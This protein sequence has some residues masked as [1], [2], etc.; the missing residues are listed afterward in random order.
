M[1]LIHE[2]LVAKYDRT[3]PPYTR[4]DYDKIWGSYDVSSI[5]T[6]IPHTAMFVPL[7]SWNDEKALTDL[8]AFAFVPELLS[9]YSSAK[10]ILTTRSVNSWHRSMQATVFAHMTSWPLFLQSLYDFE[11]TRLLRRLMRKWG[12]VFC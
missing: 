6:S 10:F 4:K 1:D 11:H 2:A 12:Q 7:M 5:L 9:A 8:P 3:I